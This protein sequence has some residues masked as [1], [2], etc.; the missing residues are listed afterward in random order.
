VTVQSVRQARMSETEYFELAKNDQDYDPRYSTAKTGGYMWGGGLIDP[1][2]KLAGPKEHPTMSLQD[3]NKRANTFREDM[4][5][6]RLRNRMRL[7]AEGSNFE[8]E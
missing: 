6:D 2:V 1:S 5:R 8:K 4:T 3:S 7:L